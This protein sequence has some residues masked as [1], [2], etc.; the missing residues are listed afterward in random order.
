MTRRHVAALYAAYTG[1][2]VALAVGAW[3]LTMRVGRW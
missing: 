3:V 2:A 1:A